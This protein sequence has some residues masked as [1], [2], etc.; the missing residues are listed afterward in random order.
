MFIK[1]FLYP[2][3]NIARV[4]ISLA[5]LEVLLPSIN[6]IFANEASSDIACGD[7][8]NF[9]VFDRE[10]KSALEKQ[11]PT[12]T[13]VL[14]RFPLRINYGDGSSISLNNH[15]SL[16]ARFTEIFSPRIRS[17]VINQ[18]PPGSDFCRGLGFAYGRGDVWVSNVGNYRIEAINI[19]TGKANFMRKS[20][21]EYTCDTEKHRI[22]IDSDQFGNLHYRSWNKPKFVTEKEDMMVKKGV[23]NPAGTGV[24]MDSNWTFRNGDAEYAVTKLGGCAEEGAIPAEA[25][26]ILHVSVAGKL[27]TEQ[28]CY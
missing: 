23:Y 24:C 9:L 1:R 4:S 13:A 21:L 19:D 27:K 16:K 12:A 11:D 25:T 6:P 26:G 14:T 17:V 8:Q 5:I 7:P 22:V 10:L 2:A 18:N 28:W 15:Q 20:M 3:T